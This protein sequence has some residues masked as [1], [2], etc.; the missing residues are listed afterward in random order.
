VVV[1]GYCTLIARVPSTRARTLA[2]AALRLVE[3]SSLKGENPQSDELLARIVPNLTSLPLAFRRDLRDTRHP[4]SA[5]R[6]PELLFPSAVFPLVDSNA[7]I[8]QVATIV[9]PIGE[10]D[11]K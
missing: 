10:R 11:A 9:V 4:I 3:V 2:K 7:S 1:E 6:S 5:D 8:K